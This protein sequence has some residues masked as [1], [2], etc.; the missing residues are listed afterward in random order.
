MQQ[1]LTSFNIFTFP[2][3][4]PTCSSFWLS[5]SSSTAAEYWPLRFGVAGLKPP[6]PLLR[7]SSG[8]AAKPAPEGASALKWLCEAYGEGAAYDE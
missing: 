6:S 5:N 2:V 4:I 8:Y 1:Q 7:P 3:M